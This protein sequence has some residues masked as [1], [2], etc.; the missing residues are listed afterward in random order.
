MIDDNPS[1]FID[2]FLRRHPAGPSFWSYLSQ[3][4]AI[5]R[6]STNLALKGKM[7]VKKAKAHVFSDI[8]TCMRFFLD[9]SAK[10]FAAG[11]GKRDDV[12][13]RFLDAYINLENL[14]HLSRFCSKVLFQVPQL[15]VSAKN[16]SKKQNEAFFQP[17]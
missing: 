15:T 4:C 11:R 3:V 2:C 17:S 1:F 13:A 16:V 14:V 7:V 10:H 12:W 6:L 9:I 8:F 5:L